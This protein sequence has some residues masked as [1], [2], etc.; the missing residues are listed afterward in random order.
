MTVASAVGSFAL[1]AGLVTIIPG[2]DTA[3]V[4]RAAMTKGNRQAFLTALGVGT[5]AL[6]WGVAAAVGIS[7]LL[8]ASTMAYTV[9]RV[10]GAGYMLWL[11]GRMVRH[12]LRNREDDPHHDEPH[13]D[14]PSQDDLR[15]GRVRTASAGWRSWRQGL[16]TNLLNPKVGAFYLSVLPQFIPANVEPLTM[17][18]LLALVH[19]LEG[20]IWFALIIL[21]TQRIR[22]WLS[23]R[24]ARRAIDG[25]TGTVLIGFGVRLGLSSH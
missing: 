6:V 2:L 23:R 3:L 21:G 19:D 20:L 25:V 5:G 14:D 12:S 16:L 10:A 15:D 8:T 24:A 4:L 9:L 13:L 22:G 17:G 11:G 7:A 18:V 1:V